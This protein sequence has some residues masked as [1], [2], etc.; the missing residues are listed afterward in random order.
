MIA[1][2][3][4]EVQVRTGER[5]EGLLFAADTFLQKL[6]S[7]FASILPGIFLEL[8]AFPARADPKTLDPQIMHNLIWILMPLTFILGVA[9]TLVLLFYRIDK[10]AHELNLA[11]LAAQTAPGE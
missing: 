11:K 7:G 10:N 4:E 5:S 8:V 3:V 2:I 6:I 1:D 9:A